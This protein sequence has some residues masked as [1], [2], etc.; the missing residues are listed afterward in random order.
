MFVLSF[1]RKHTRQLNLD[2]HNTSKL[3]RRCTT[4]WADI[5]GNMCHMHCN[6]D[7][8]T[9]EN[10]TPEVPTIEDNKFLHNKFY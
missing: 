3:H 7:R 10:N 8:V 6:V 1:G 9:K 5:T 4:I 2:W